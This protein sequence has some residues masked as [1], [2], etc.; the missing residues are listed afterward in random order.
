MAKVQP[1][2]RP[3]IGQ[4]ARAQSF[5]FLTMIAAWG[6]I[7]GAFIYYPEWITT[8]LRFMTRS[9]EALA[10][11]VPQPWGARLE[12]MLK[13]LGGMIWIQI[14]SAIAL[15]RLVLWVPFHLWRL[16]RERRMRGGHSV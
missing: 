11:R 4:L 9:T 5:R 10:D 15:L 7:F 6:L 16:S 14:A 13:E 12:I 3:T 1:R 2:N 8:W